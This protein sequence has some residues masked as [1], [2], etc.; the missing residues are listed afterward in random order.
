MFRVMEPSASEW[1]D[2]AKEKVRHDQTLD[3]SGQFPLAL[4]GV[5]GSPML[6]QQVS[7]QR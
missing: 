2:E 5:H 3:G 4:F 1:K 6:G 7:L